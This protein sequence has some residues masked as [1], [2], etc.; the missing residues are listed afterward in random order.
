MFLCFPTWYALRWNIHFLLLFIDQ[1][2]NKSN[3]GLFNA[4]YMISRCKPIRALLENVN[5]YNKEDHD[6]AGLESVEL[7]QTLIGYIAG[8]FFYLLCMKIKTDILWN[9]YILSISYLGADG[10]FDIQKDILT[11]N[12]QIWSNYQYQ[13]RFVIDCMERGMHLTEKELDMTIKK[14]V[15][16]AGTGVVALNCC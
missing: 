8:I 1:D 13:N 4:S 15:D 16:D 5:E 2:T 6:G 11:K 3:G 10:L 14:F 7:F 9:T 12:Q